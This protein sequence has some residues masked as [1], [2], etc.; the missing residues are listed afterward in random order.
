MKADFYSVI[1]HIMRNKYV[2]KIENEE[3]SKCESFYRE[4]KLKRILNDIERW[5]FINFILQKQI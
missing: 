2:E 5:T 3:L 4:Q 1:D